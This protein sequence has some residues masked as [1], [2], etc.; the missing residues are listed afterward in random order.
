MWTERSQ[1]LPL[2]GEVDSDALDLVTSCLKK[3]AEDLSA[4]DSSRSRRFF[5]DEAEAEWRK[6]YKTLSAE[7]PGLLGAITARGETLVL[8]LSLV[9]AQLDGSLQICL[10]HLKA[11]LEVWRYCEE[12]ARFIFGDLLGDETAD[13]VLDFLRTAGPAGAT[14]TEISNSFARNKPSAEIDQALRLLWSEK[15]VRTQ[16]EEFETG[17]SVGRWFAL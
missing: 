9:Y 1:Y 13:S 3:A 4:E 11:G 14:R 5:D 6:R 15:Y 2:G 8:R 16:K 10:P 12:S 7:R 17:R